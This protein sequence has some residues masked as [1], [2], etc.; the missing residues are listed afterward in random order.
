MRKQFYKTLETVIKTD[1]RVIVLLGDIGV[2]GCRN[3]FSNFPNQIINIGVCEQSMI[4]MAA[5]LAREGFIPIVHTIA[6]FMVERGLEQLKLD[7]GYQKLPVKIV[8]IGG[9]YDYASLGVT[10]HCPADVAIIKTIPSFNIIVPGCAEEFNKLFLNTYDN[11][12]PTYYRLSDYNHTKSITVSSVYPNVIKEGT[13]GTIIVVGNLLSNVL[14]ATEKLDVSVLYYTTLHPFD[15]SILQSHYNRGKIVIVEPFYEGTLVN[16]VVN[17]FIKRPIAVKSI[18][19]S[20]YF[21]T[22]YGKKEEH[23]KLYRL[24]PL[25]LEQQIKDFIF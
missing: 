19:V 17:A 5:G 24:T 10:H 2:F 16:D 9:S 12:S 21:H 14:D 25:Q 18:G 15:T 8:S 22:Y 6:P 11:S 23:D 13:L 1:A 20:R 3:I 7:V 4:S